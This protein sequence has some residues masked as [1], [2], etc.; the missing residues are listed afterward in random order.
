MT[1]TTTPKQD[2]VSATILRSKLEAI[3]AEMEA[4]LANTAYSHAISV[5]RQCAAALFTEQGELV[6]V[7]NPLYMVP[8]AMTAEAIVDRFQFDLSG[9]DVLLTNDPY[10]GGTRVQTFTAVAPVQHGDSI[11]MYLAVCGQTEDIGGDFRGNLN[12]AATEI[13][14]EGVRCTPVRLVREGK[15]RK[16]VRQTLE[17]NSR[18]PDALSLDIDAMLATVAVGRQ[19][20]QGLLDGHGV[21]ALSEGV[22]WVLDYSERRMRAMIEQLPRGRYQGSCKLAHDC[23][24]QAKT[25]HVALEAEV[26]NL[27]IDFAGTDAQSTGF[28]NASRATCAT[29]ALLPLLAAFGGEVPCNAGAL[30][31]V[32]VL[33]PEG[34]VVNPKYPAPT[35]W[36]LQHLGNEIS[37]AVCEALE[38]A[39]PG[40][41]GRVTA[42]SILLYAVHRQARHGQ[43]VEQLEV[44][45]FSDLVQGDSDASA[46]QDGWGLP[47]IAARVPLP[48]IELYEA[49][50]GGRVEQLEYAIDSCGAGEHRG[51]PGTVAVIALP[52]LEAGALHLTAVVMASG[53]AGAIAGDGQQGPGN[54]VRLD[55]D[56]ST[57][58]INDLLVNHRVGADARLTVM[59]GGGS[60]RG[61]ALRRAPQKVATDIADGLVSVGAARERYGVVVDPQTLQLDLCAT[62]ELRDR[63]IAESSQA[64]ET[65]HV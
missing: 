24:G 9:E 59:M 5:S 26:G 13:W 28:V 65:V 2:L 38:K 55:S 16:D 14:A 1:D 23:H 8:M 4:T 10:G 35:G 29:F 21:K 46:E 31:C 39:I 60:G 43:T 42:N 15:L 63:H 6:A 33:A 50:R 34:T 41:A 52:Q 22:S 11:A 48:S 62:Q 47:G 58:E 7:S 27:T 49:G 25:V 19:R 53:A 30:R 44:I 51:S 61:S 17:L 45:D 18:N 57:I 54:A 32:E 37:N 64:K 3:V 36:G 20:L 12:P 40:R 56:G